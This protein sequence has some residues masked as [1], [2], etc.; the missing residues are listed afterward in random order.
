MPP[1]E[2]KASPE[3]TIGVE[4]ELGVIDAET[5]ELAPK[6]NEI[7]DRVPAN[8]ED[9]VKPEF[10]Q[11]YLEFNTGVC[12]TVADAG[13][14]LS[15]RLK[16]GYEVAEDLGCTYLWSGTHPT[17][18]WDQQ[19]ITDDERYHWLLDTMQLVARRLLCFGFHVHVGVDS[20]DKAIQM[21]DRLMRHLPVLLAMSSNSPW[22]NGHDTGL[23]S[24]RS[25]IMESLPTAG[26]PET[27]RNWSEFTW[28]IE[29]LR[30][31]NFIRS[32]KEIWWDVRPVGRFGTVEVRVMDTPLR[33]RDLLGLTAVVQCLVV[34]ISD[35]IDKGAYQ[36]DCHPMIARQNKWHA[37]RWGLDATLVDPDTMLAA[38][39]RQLA[40][41]MIDLCKPV[42]S[43]LGC[44]RE[45]GFAES[46]LEEGTGTDRQLAFAQDGSANIAPGILGITGKPWEDC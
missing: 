17:S 16:W 19:V 7:L 46:I 32:S 1:L 38:P 21:C 22:W 18:R 3:P 35:D 45:L 29:H 36:V 37:V 13:K 26:L 6:A 31:T 12:D 34:G 23:A 4:I 43:R 20:P 44:E 10:M 42:A 39:A 15:K 5:G 40:R 28:L 25:K 41:R 14:D 33:M 8:W 11:S 24:Y 2:F 30:S 27:M 9:F